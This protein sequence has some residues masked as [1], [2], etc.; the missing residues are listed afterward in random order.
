MSDRSFVQIVARR[1][2][3]VS[4]IALLCCGFSERVNAQLKGTVPHRLP[5]IVGTHRP[6]PVIVVGFLGG[7][8]RNDDDRHPEVQFIEDLQMEDF[9]GEVR[10]ETI[11]NRRREKARKTILRWLDVNQDGHLS[12]REKAAARIVLFGHS[13]GGDAVN[14]LA[15][16]LGDQ[17]I[18]VLL[19]IQV[20]SISRGGNDDC[21]VPSNV[22]E[23]IN[24]YQTQGWLHGC[25]H[26]RAENPAATKLLGDFRFRYRTL[27][28]ECKS[29]PWYARRFFR[30]HIAIECDPR[31]WSRIESMIRRRLPPDPFALDSTEQPHNTAKIS[32][33]A[34]TK[35]FS[36]RRTACQCATCDQLTADSQCRSRRVASA[37][38]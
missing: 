26:L 10:A 2:L 25:Q 33:N 17:G 12:E 15:R 7:R 5:A 29:F 31:V 19:T 11:E 24:F 6:S 35:S 1:V 22:A 32:S 28:P 14:R 34:T 8:V 36:I 18:P 13:W 3:V 4:T 27:P 38:H 30:S 16:E 21:L 23:A 20:D 9:Y 37:G